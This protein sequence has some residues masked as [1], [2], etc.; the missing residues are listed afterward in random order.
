MDFIFSIFFNIAVNTNFNFLELR[1]SCSEFCF[2]LIVLDE[3]N[4][5]G[6]KLRRV[7][8]ARNSRVKASRF[9][10]VMEAS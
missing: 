7:S 9:W 10:L 8:V 6:D 5:H 4:I 2:L 1:Q 3:N